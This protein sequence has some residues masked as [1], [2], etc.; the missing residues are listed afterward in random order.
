MPI[1][2][3]CLLRYYIPYGESNKD[4]RDINLNLMEL[5]LTDLCSWLFR[6]KLTNIEVTLK[7]EYRLDQKPVPLVKH[8]SVKQEHKDKD[9]KESSVSDSV[10]KE[11]GEDSEEVS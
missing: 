11:Q 9:N 4:H 8:R 7:K 10:K 3:D 1:I 5:M 6:K 2:C